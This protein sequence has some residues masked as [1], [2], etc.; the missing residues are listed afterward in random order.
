MAEDEDLQQLVMSYKQT[1]LGEH[2][3]RVLDHMKVCAKFNIAIVPNNLG[4]IDVYEVMRQ[5]GMRSVIIN[6]EKM[7]NKKPG[8]SKG[9]QNERPETIANTSSI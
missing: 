1:F 4:R 8:E 2:G 7:I 6:I 3:K 5:E 9:I